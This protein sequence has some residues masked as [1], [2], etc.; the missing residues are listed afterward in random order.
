MTVPMPLMIAV[1]LAALLGLATALTWV[2]RRLLGVWQDRY[3][4][5]RVGPGGML[6]AVADGIKILF[7]QD[8]IPPF[9]DRAVFVLAP[10]IGMMTVL[11]SFAVI[12]VTAWWSIASALNVG[13]LFVLAAMGMGVYSV[14]LAGWASNSKYAL[15]GGLR[16]AAQMISYEVF[17]GLS[18]LGVVMQARSFSLRD[19]VLAQSGL[20]F[21]IPQALG[22]AVFMLAGIAETHRL[23]FDLPEGE[24]EL[25][26]GFHT[27]YSGMK[28]GMF[29]L[30]EYAGIV[31]V[32]ALVTTLYL[33]GWQGPLLPGGL[34]FA[35][36]VAALVVLFVLL[37]AALPRLRY[38]QL[39]ALGWKILLPLS[40]LNIVATGAVLLLRAPGG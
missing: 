11:L 4:P 17:M 21:V 35:L 22:C 16:A 28:F 24:N 18:L 31:L 15:L 5:N 3:G 33:G 9:A 20:W 7:K 36:K 23:P 34:W 1:T 27:E 40:L 6:Q 14:V 30:A 10:A 12:P 2:E 37:R 38:D 8:W 25:G 29:F 32:S 26:A 39:M 13:L 19:I